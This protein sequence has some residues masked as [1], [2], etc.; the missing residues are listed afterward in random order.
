MPR[1]HQRHGQTDGRLAIAIPRQ[2]YRAVKSLLANRIK[3]QA[4]AHWESFKHRQNLAAVVI[5]NEQFYQLA[6]GRSAPSTYNTTIRGGL[7]GLRDFSIIQLLTSTVLVSRIILKSC[8]PTETEVLTTISIDH[9]RARYVSRTGGYKYMACPP[10]PVSGGTCPLCPPWF[11]RP[12][13]AVTRPWTDRKWVS[14]W[15]I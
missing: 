2:H 8:K 11:R 15:F 6:D 5:V 7:G 13:T 9:S 3:F 12:C 10:S 14:K 1:V 4:H